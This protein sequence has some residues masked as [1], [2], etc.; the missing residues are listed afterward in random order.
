MQETRSPFGMLNTAIR[1]IDRISNH[2]FCWGVFHALERGMCQSLIIPKFSGDILLLDILTNHHLSALYGFDWNM[3]PQNL[4]LIWSYMS[5][6][7]NVSLKIVLD[8]DFQ[9]SP[10]QTNRIQQTHTTPLQSSSKTTA[11][12]MPIS[13]SS[14]LWQQSTEGKW[15]KFT[16]NPFKKQFGQCPEKLV[17]NL[18]EK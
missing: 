8:C 3:V 14:R 16:N 13:S 7:N 10:R 2:V 1:W 15:C 18:Q 5:Y 6:I 11:S 4:M 17:P 9:L 12:A